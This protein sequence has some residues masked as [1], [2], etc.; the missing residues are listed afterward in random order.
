MASD[1]NTF[2]FQLLGQP[3]SPQCLTMFLMQRTNFQL[4]SLLDSTRQSRFALRVKAT[5]S[6]AQDRAHAPNRHCPSSAINHLV[7][8][9]RTFR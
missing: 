7:R 3:A 1:K 6:Q 8:L 5:A 2:N 9:N 4:Q